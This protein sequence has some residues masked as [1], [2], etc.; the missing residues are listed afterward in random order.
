MPNEFFLLTWQ[1]REQMVS[2]VGF[3]GKRWLPEC[4]WDFRKNNSEKHSVLGAS[5]YSE[6]VLRIKQNV[7]VL[8]FDSILQFPKLCVAPIIYLPSIGIVSIIATKTL[9]DISYAMFFLHS[10]TKCRHQTKACSC[11]F[12]L[13][14]FW[15]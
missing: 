12:P 7:S 14:P 5:V 6:C 13:V 15:H 3:L 11:R 9:M 8:E 1:Q 4:T 10:R 2:V